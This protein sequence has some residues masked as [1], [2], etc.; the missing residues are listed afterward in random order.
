[1]G[2]GCR[3]IAKL[4]TRI[5]GRRPKGAREGGEVDARLSGRYGDLGMWRSECRFDAAGAGAGKW[6]QGAMGRMGV[7]TVVIADGGWVVERC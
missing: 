1:M 3:P 4:A 5:E 2:F 6:Q 7:V